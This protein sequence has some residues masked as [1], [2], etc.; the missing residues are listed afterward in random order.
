MP[1]IRQLA[2]KLSGTEG[3][4][5][6]EAAIVLPVAFMLLLG[7]VE[8]GRVFNINSTIQQAAQQ[9]AI[10]AARE[11]CATCGSGSPNVNTAINAVLQASNLDPT[12]IKQP[13]AAPTCAGVQTCIACPTP[14]P[15]PT[16]ACTTSGQVYICQNVQLNPPATAQPP[17]QPPQCGTVVSF[18]YPFTFILPFTSINASKIILTAQAQS[19]MEN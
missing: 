19:R 14:Y 9:G 16:N 6:L 15:Q 10:T 13:A 11:F 3:Q 17:T 1:T 5:L 8:F 12:Q 18:Q 7:I 2:R 4:E